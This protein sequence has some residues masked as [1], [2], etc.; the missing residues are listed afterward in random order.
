MHLWEIHLVPHITYNLMEEVDVS[1]TNS[2]EFRILLFQ[3]SLI[4]G[5]GSSRISY[6]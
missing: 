5:L 6:F 3:N 2:S 1:I 4:K